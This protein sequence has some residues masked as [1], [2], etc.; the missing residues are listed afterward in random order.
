M[1]LTNRIPDFEKRARQ[2]CPIRQVAGRPVGKF[3]RSL[4]ALCTFILFSTIA[5]AQTWLAAPGSNDWNTAANWVPANVPDSPGGT[6]VF[7]VS[8]ITDPTVNS[9]V[10]IDGV[11][12][13][14][15]A[16]TYTI[17]NLGGITLGGAGIVNNSV[18]V[19]T[20]SNGR[21][22]DFT[23]ASSAGNVVLNNNTALLSSIGFRDT[24]TAATSTINNTNSQVVV[25]F[26]DNATAG[27]ATITNSGAGSLVNFRGQSSAL[28]STI[29]NLG[30]TTTSITDFFDTS[31]AG[32]AVLNNNGTGS[33]IDF[34]NGTTAGGATINNSGPLSLLFFRDNATA[35][36]AII[37][38]SGAVSQTVFNMSSNAGS[39]TISNSGDSSG[40]FFANSSTAGNATINNNSSFGTLIF[41]GVATAAN[42]TI[43]RSGRLS[44]VRFFDNATA[45]GATI[46]NSSQ[47]IVFFSGKSTAANATI[48]N[49]GATAFVDF[50]ENATAGAAVIDSSG[51]GSVIFFANSSN[52]GSATITN[53]GMGGLV[54]FNDRGS[55]FTGTINNLGPSSTIHFVDISTAGRAVLNNSGNGSMIEFFNGATAGRATVNNLGLLSTI[56]FF[57]TSTAGSAVLN[58]SSNLGGI[59][60]FDRATAGRATI[61][62]SSDSFVRFNG[63]SSALTATINNVGLA[64]T[65]DFFQSS[66]A[67][68][69]VLNNSS[70]L[71]G[72]AFFNSA[73]A[74]TATINNSSATGLINFLDNATAGAAIIDNSASGSQTVFNIKSDAGSATISNSGSGSF[75]NFRG[76]SSAGTA[77]LNNNGLSSAIIFFGTTTAANAHIVNRGTNSQTSFGAS[78][79]AAAATITNSGAGGAT[80]FA[81]RATGATSVLINANRTALIDISQLTTPGISVGSVEG[82]GDLFLGSKNLTVGSINTSTTF[83][84]II[85]DGG[86]GGGTGGSLTKVGTGTFFLSGANTFS[87]GTDLQGGTLVVA[88]DRAL[89]NGNFR[90]TGGVL[91]ASGPTRDINV[92]GN[93]TQTGGELNLRIG[94]S[95]DG[96]YDRLAVL[97]Q[98]NLG[99]SLRVDPINGFQ[100]VSD[101]RFILVDAPRGLIGVFS[102]FDDNLNDTALQP[103]LTYLSNQ[104]I[105]EYL[106]SAFLPF[107]LTPNQRAVA[108]ALD[109]VVNDSDA[110]D[111]IG[112]LNTLPLTN[113]PAAFDLIAPEEIGA[114]FEITRS[115]AKV[116]AFHVQRRLDEIHAPAPPAEEHFSK[117]GKAVVDGK[118]SKEI[119]NIAPPE[120]RWGL[121]ATGSGEFVSVGDTF[122]ARGYDFESGGVTVGLDYKFSDHFAAGVLFNY[123]RTNGELTGDG[124]IDVDAVRGGLYASVFGGGAYLNAYVGG[125]YLDC[126]TERAGL[127]GKVRGDTDGGEFNAFVSAGYDAH[128]GHV[129]VGPI[130]SYQYT[131][132]SYGSFQ[133]HGSLAPLRID[134][135][136]GES[137]RTNLGLRLSYTRA[138]GRVIFTPEVRAT[139]QHEFGDSATAT[140]ARFSF[141]GPKFN[142]HSA[143]VGED[144]ALLSAGFSLQFSPT[145]AAFAYYE[146]E[147]GR[148]NYDVR[149]VVVGARVNF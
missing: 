118:T 27:S 111:L 88:S 79:T 77:T 145:C 34:F 11:T 3:T 84:G 113:L 26:Y 37:D 58:N 41:S 10:D 75:V 23:G 36:T 122:N 38:N 143:E 53:G 95:A 141:G 33:I 139:W 30:L 32:S 57:Q 119:K 17:N 51:A 109:A 117:D 72:F 90:L 147:L 55:A 138:I 24:S 89:G 40:T 8:T 101:D 124:D 99:G 2:S 115:A 98:A 21:S 43:N 80:V 49:S 13:N 120:P 6:A 91:R 92:R 39:A 108:G 144:S 71:G 132:T 46:N 83:S 48:N 105:L 73:T 96:E 146:G 31:T 16:S 93:Y 140:S 78:S 149:N 148:E 128:F 56:D 63:A 44:S 94:G 135:A 28:T 114:I 60:F 134:S 112:F 131:Y 12:F 87:G 127:L 20:I 61:N 64:S 7:V 25:T 142:V 14:A 42:A 54:S 74:G 121:W 130:A 116:Q 68:S 82:N 22:L 35:G 136:N 66:T 5:P 69:A 15:G 4:T 86:F 103:T 137:S 52:A 106:Q 29:N 9:L 126:D 104:V 100:P 19:Q 110:V 123:T 76:H 62:N 81:D 59:D 70:N 18:A 45:A 97:G 50:A 47:G 1:A 133:E 129:T 65:V 102:E 67:G 107:A 85:Q 125:G